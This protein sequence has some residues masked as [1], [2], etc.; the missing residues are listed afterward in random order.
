MKNE[1]I[2]FLGGKLKK[3]RKQKAYTQEKF[4]ELLEI[5]PK[6]LSR[7]EC[8]KTSPSLSLVVKA[9]KIFGIKVADMFN[10]N[11]FPNKTKLI[12]EIT[13]ILENSTEDEVK[14]FYK[15]ILNL[16]N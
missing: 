5:D 13:E 9:S 15:I 11:Y 12:K 7:I 16:K 2:K 6:H 14:I 10:E 1:M 3:L 8:G 4:S